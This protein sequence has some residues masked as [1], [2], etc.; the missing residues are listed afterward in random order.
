MDDD[1]S[2]TILCLID[3]IKSEDHTTKLNAIKSLETIAQVIGQ[4]R[5]RE[6][7]VPYTAELLDDDNEEILIAVAMKLGDLSRYV[8]EPRHMV[9]LL[10]PLNTL[11]SNEENN[12]RE[13]AVQ[14]LNLIAERLPSKVIEEAYLPVL[15]NLA[16][17][18]WYSARIAACSL[19]SSI[20]P[21]LSPE[22]QAELIKLFIN[23]G[24]DD[25]PM[26]R[27]AAASNL[28]SL[29]S[30]VSNG[31]LGRLL[32]GLS[33][34]EH[35]SVRQAVLESISK[36][37]P[38]YK[39]LIQLIKK[40]AKDKS[41][42]VRY[43]LVEHMQL[44]LEPF[45]SA[46]NIINEVVSLLNDSEPEV[47]C[48]ILSNLSF[49]IQKLDKSSIEVYIMP[50]YEKLAKDPSQYVRLSLVQAICST[51]S[52]FDVETAV[53]KLL[54]IINTLIKD[55]S[56]DVR[57]SFADS[58]HKFN[59][60]IGPEKVV[61]YSVPL[62]LQMMKDN[63]WRLRHKV[64][65][66]LPQV[67]DMIGA[68]SFNVNI[69]E[70]VGSW[71]K[72][73]VFAVREATLEAIKQIST[74]DGYGDNWVKTRILSFVQDLAKEQ[75]FTRRMTALY[76]L[77]KFGHLIGG[78]EFYALVEVL[79]SDSIANIRFNVA[80]TIKSNFGKIKGQ[81]FNRILDKMKTDPDPD[82]KFFSEEAL[83]ELN[84]KN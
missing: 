14:S 11:A 6:E 57:I 27:R 46:S 59:E 40:L 53:Q 77:N 8:G 66:C 4:E 2:D 26:V 64:V 7:L 34:D 15:N 65:E 56:F 24:K 68:E 36:I 52:H 20:F 45:D 54:P 74:M 49:I 71:L 61:A 82:V 75:I 48:I 80:K 67:A 39:D 47:K 35:D 55:E 58:M 28:G 9:C 79:A 32:E 31:D 22:H 62:I 81:N 41:W 3:E 51:S 23:L 38:R 1:E 5:T 72:D 13:K 76:A 17:N 63:Q 10:P 69:A 73:P 12:V 18:D 83:K 42:R 44:Y 50:S 60:S 21:K 84:K 16:I 30:L 19:F 29:C 70:N 25:T 33:T 43:T 78:K 37:I